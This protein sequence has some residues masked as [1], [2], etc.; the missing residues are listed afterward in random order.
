MA[1]HHPSANFPSTAW[2]CVHAAQDA[3]HPQ[4]LAALNRL[5]VAYWKPVF[6][7]LRA[8]GHAAP[9]A[10]DLTQEFFA[11]FLKHGFRQAADQQRGRF[12]DYLRTILRRFAFD[13]TAR[14]K[15]QT[16]FE[17]QLVS[18]HTLIQDSDRTYEPPA[19]ETPD[20]AFDK[21]WKAD[22]LAAV[23]RSLHDF[24][25]GLN[26]AARRD[27]DI[28]AARHVL[29]GNQSPP[30]QEALAERFGVTRDQVRTA[31]QKVGKR[32]EH[33]LRQEL[34]D[35]LGTEADIDVEIK[36]LL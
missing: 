31:L 7:F 2:S 5:I 23:R 33:F 18:I 21:Q 35:Q 19:R 26:S 22:V 25:H 11:S 32:Y 16:R 28:F 9:T 24:Y 6:H 3:D 8:S 15:R 30:T 13:Q 4:H 1:F 36:A 14:A 27:F 29:D 10:E 34:R 12:R 17:R 20:E